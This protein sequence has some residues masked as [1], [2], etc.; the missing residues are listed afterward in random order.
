MKLPSCMHWSGRYC[1]IDGIL[2]LLVVM[3]PFVFYWN[4]Y[5]D[6]V[7]FPCAVMALC[8]NIFRKISTF[9]WFSVYVFIS[10]FLPLLFVLLFYVVIGHYSFESFFSNYLSVVMYAVALYAVVGNYNISWIYL[11][12]IL[13]GI[14][15]LLFSL[16]VLFLT[17]EM[18]S[19]DTVYILEINRNTFIPLVTLLGII[20][21]L[22]VF[23]G[24]KTS[25]EKYLHA[26]NAV[27]IYCIMLVSQA[28]CGISTFFS[29]WV[30]IFIHRSKIEKKYILI[31][32]LFTALAVFYVFTMGR[33][34]EGISDIQAYQCGDRETSLGRRFAIWNIALYAFM[35][36]PFLGWGENYMQEIFSMENISQYISQ[37]IIRLPH[38]HNELLEM[39]IH[40]GMLGTAGLLAALLF[41]WKRASADIPFQGVVAGIIFAGFF[42][43]YLSHQRL[44]VIVVVTIYLIRNILEPAYYMPAKQQGVSC[45]YDR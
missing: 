42:D 23:L 25:P 31:L 22:E 8:V 32:F 33:G 29:I 7:V 28:R 10:P 6:F 34:V 11:L 5:L 39:T 1:Y 27:V 44:A 16:Y 36:H 17:C 21:F 13:H 38:L 41:L 4:R 2:L 43:V 24:N 14:I 35:E 18:V 37:N 19:S 26:I 12:K 15:L 45:R 9:N 20:S 3:F 40:F 30:V